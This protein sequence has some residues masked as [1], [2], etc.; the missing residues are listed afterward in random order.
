[1][2]G[3]LNQMHTEE[4]EKA[5]EEKGFEIWSDFESTEL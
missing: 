4:L 3:H 2:T 1:V 5:A